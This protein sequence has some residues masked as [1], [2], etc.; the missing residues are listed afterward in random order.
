MRI[1]G[2]DLRQHRFPR[3]WWGFD[4]AAVAAFLYEA[5]DDY[6]AA[7][8][9]LGRLRKEAA[10]LDEHLQGHRAREVALGETLR[11]AQRLADEMREQAH[12]EARGMLQ[13]AQH[14]AELV[15]QQVPNPKDTST[16][17]QITGLHLARLEAEISL[18]ASLTTLRS[19]LAR[20]GALDQPERVA[21]SRSGGLTVGDPGGR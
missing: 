9:E 8:S 7:L 18:E 19:V 11:T 6:E 15:L 13:E 10:R 17:R 14:R 20:V 1:S 3:A 5:A 12:E 21:D 16:G 4:R 2:F